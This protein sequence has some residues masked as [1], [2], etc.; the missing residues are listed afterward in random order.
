MVDVVNSR[1]Q[2]ETEHQFIET[3]SSGVTQSC[4]LTISTAAMGNVL[5]VLAPLAE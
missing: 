3:G 2:F 4:H 5:L 1:Q